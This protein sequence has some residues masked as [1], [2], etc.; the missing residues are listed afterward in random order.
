MRQLRARRRG[1]RLERDAGHVLYST[2]SV[3]CT[4]DVGRPRAARRTVLG[5]RARARARADLAVAR[6][7]CG[8]E[9]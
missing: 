8:R 3:L 1:T 6:G 2:Y 5:G 7:F 9:L 4:Q